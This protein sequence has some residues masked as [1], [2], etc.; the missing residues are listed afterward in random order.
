M[1]WATQE[2]IPHL[3]SAFKISYT[4]AP[5]HEGGSFEFLKR[6][7]V[8]APNYESV[9]IHPEAKHINTMVERF[10]VANG[11]PAKLSKTP[12]LQNPTHFAANSPALSDWMSSK[13]RSLVGMSMYMA[14]ERYDIQ[15]ATKTLA[16][17]LKA[18]TQASWTALGRLVGYLRY[19]KDFAFHMCK[20]QKGQ[21]FMETLNGV[22]S[23]R[24]ENV[25]EVYSDS[26][27]NG[28]TGFKSTSSAMHVLNGLI[29]HSTS[30]S[31]KAISLSSTEAE[32]YA[33]S[34]ATCD[35]LFL[36]N[37][38]QFLTGD[39]QCV[40][41]HVDNSAVRNVA[42]KLG[43]GRLRH[44]SGRMMWMQQL[45][46]AK[47]IEIRQVSATYNITDLNTKGLTRERFF[48]LLWM[49][50][51]VDA[52]GRV[53]E[54]E[55]ARMQTKSVMKSQIS[56]VNR[57]INS[58]L[59]TDGTKVP[60]LSSISKQVLRV[61]A[62]YS[63]LPM[64]EAAQGTEA[65]SLWLNL[66][67]GFAFLI[68]VAMGFWFSSVC[69]MMPGSNNEPEGEPDAFSLEQSLQEHGTYNEALV[70]GFIS[71]CVG[72]IETLR[73]TTGPEMELQLAEL[74][75]Q[76]LGC[77]KTFEDNGLNSTSVDRLL[78]VTQQFADVDE[79]FRVQDCAH[80]EFLLTGDE[81]EVEACIPDDM[82]EEYSAMEIAPPFEQ[83]S[84]EH[85]AQWMIERLTKRLAEYVEA[86]I[87]RR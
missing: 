9:V 28:G 35:S 51:H 13:Y 78:E 52:D 23:E 43:V 58:E 55:Y 26:D 80:Q 24:T 36:R 6:L 81:P 44:I 69:I 17:N 25:V 10:A 48:A 46:R 65:L 16:C 70:Y 72:R 82:P 49:I 53:G 31:Q 71:A 12:C 39:V 27:W 32:W 38:L 59:G 19:S 56:V 34:A 29:V 37:I 83:N 3:E 4:F 57:A 67:M 79:N 84:P 62:T 41:L 50:G 14:Q 15:Y 68:L 5:R 63:L 47:E 40:V 8:I 45:L 60:H 73:S 21:V 20:T 74:E 11:K 61:L 54:N 22:E 30:R 76:L 1:I 64:A 85:M 86:G 18:P 7:H 75:Q 77:F 42:A 2:L 87:P 33:G 66:R